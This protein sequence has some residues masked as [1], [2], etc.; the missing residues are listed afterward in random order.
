[1]MGV[2]R[3]PPL[4]T[5]Y[6]YQEVCMGVWLQTAQKPVNRP[7]GWKGNFVLFQMLATGVWE[8]SGQGEERESGGQLSKGRFPPTTLTSRG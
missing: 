6:C 7:G 5:P 8:G 1:M 2:S 4:L 3:E